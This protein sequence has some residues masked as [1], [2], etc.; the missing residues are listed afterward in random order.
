[1]LEERWT[2]GHERNQT[3]FD[4][5]STFLTLLE[6]LQDEERT[7]C[8]PVRVTVLLEGRVVAHSE[9]ATVLTILRLYL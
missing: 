9:E 4:L 7:S 3:F 2:S 5:F 1:M 6:T 8:P